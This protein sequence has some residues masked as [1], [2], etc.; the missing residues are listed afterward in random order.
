MQKIQD[1]KN[2]FVQLLNNQEYV[3]DK[4]GVKTIE[5]VGESY[6]ADE[7]VIFGTLNM[8]YAQKE[9]QWYNSQSLNVFDISKT[10]KIWRQVCD[11]NGFINSNYGWIIFSEENSYQYL[12]CLRTLRKDKD[13]RRAMMIYTR[14]SMQYEYNKNGM[15]DFICTNTVQCLIR[16]N[17]LI[18]II[19]QRSCDA[20]FGAKNDLFWGRYIQKKLY[21][22][23]I[24]DY[25]E[26]KLGDIIHQV[27]SLH[28]YERHFKFIEE[29]I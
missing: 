5:I 7:E 2:L 20:V 28:V 19:N 6:I 8:K 10:P 18:Y 24:E 1:I 3:I 9:V 27:G 17:K 11:K 25:P 26:L 21:N 16:N 22:D 4:S 23:L 15:S 13:S 29:L 12:N 14:P